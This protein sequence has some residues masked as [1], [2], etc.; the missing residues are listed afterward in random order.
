MGN[1]NFGI[2]LGT[3][4]SGIGHYEN[5]KV[6]LLKNPVG[7]KETLPSVVAYKNERIII[8]DKA[9]EQLVSNPASVFSSFKRKMGTSE[10]YTV[11]G[12]KET[13]PVELSALVLKELFNFSLNEKVTSAVITIPASFD[14]I[15]SNA[16]KE[17]GYRSGLREVV[18]LQ[19]PIAA[20]LAYSNENDL[21][22]TEQKKW[23]V[24]DFGGGTFDAAIVNINER[25]LKVIDNKGNNFLGGVDLDLQLLAKVVIPKLTEKTNLTDIWNQINDP[26]N[27]P[28]Q[29]LGKYLLYQTEEVKKELSLKE[30]AWLELSFSEFD[31]DLEL[32]ISRHEI[33]EIIAPIFEDSFELLEG[34]VKENHFDFSDFERIIL[35]GGTTY[36]PYIRAELKKRTQLVIDSTI[37][38]TTAVIIG[39]TYYAGNKMSGLDA[40]EETEANET[41]KAFDITLSVESQTQDLEELI[42]FKT[43][44]LEEGYFRVTRNDGGFDSGEVAF[45]NQASEFVTLL[46]KQVNYFTITILD[47]KRNR[48][49]TKDNIAISHGFYNVD[50][51]PLPNDICIELDADDETYLEVIFKKNTILPLKKSVYK[52]FSRSIAKG[53]DDKI[54]I[55]IV[56]G[57]VGT[58]PGAN[59]NIGY[60]EIKGEDLNDDLIRGTDIEMNFKISES[61]D[62]T[63]EIYVPSADHEITK[64]FNPQYQGDVDNRKILNE[65]NQGLDVIR[66][67]LALNNDSE[68]YVLLGKLSKIKSELEDVKGSVMLAVD[69]ILTVNKFQLLERKRRLLYEVDRLVF[70]RDV[71]F[72]MDEYTHQKEALLIQESEFSPTMRNEFN[73]I[74]KDEKLFLQSGDKFLIRRKRKALEK[75]AQ[76]LYFNS[77]DSYEHI[78]FML[79]LMDPEEFN[80]YSKVKKLLDQG[81]V[82]AEKNELKKLK[83]ICYLIYPY[84]KDKG[85]DREMFSGTGLK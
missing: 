13:H 63:V 10:L 1:I 9:N 18:L 43:P 39:A 49:Y 71:S 53:S 79:R 64:T 67:Q 68:D 82:A 37:D 74:V 83:S 48:L 31:L 55:N 32:K 16:T 35:V 51:Q 34:L 24:Y 42:A 14:T 33:N 54:I 25:E 59:L 84:I 80:N 66:E 41:E 62:L 7:F 23:L 44:A 6:M 36:I 76:T 60:V 4:N 8:G 46:A 77:D 85:R 65:L 52:T 29:K 11:N 78:F 45:K 5:G 69:E 3:T 26:N 30:E 38:P 20:C 15:Q 19:E 27:I 58:M 17:A 2:D 47:L 50:G 72:E 12:E 21:N 57:K 56:E 73:T 61:R 81:E 70:L 28:Y 75:L 22:I 40:N